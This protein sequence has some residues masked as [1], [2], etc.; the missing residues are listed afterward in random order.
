MCAIYGQRLSLAKTRGIEREVS[1]VLRSIMQG[2]IDKLMGAR[3]SDLSD[4]WASLY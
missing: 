3:V 2:S 4:G 1:A